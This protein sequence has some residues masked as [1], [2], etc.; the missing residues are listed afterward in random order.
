MTSLSSLL[1]VVHLIG[2]A[3][4]VGCATAKVYLLLK[5]NADEFFVPVFNRV[6]RP[7]TRLI[8][9]GIILLI[10]S[11]IGWLLLGYSFTPLLVV[12]VALVVMILVLGPVID[13]RVEPEFRRLSPAEGE[14]AS[15]EFKAVRRRYLLLEIT[16][17]LLFYAIILLWVLR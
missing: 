10:A 9:T 14:R 17:T 2:L 16:A 7:L 5:C 15:Q 8:V 3:L 11:G 1:S 6:A 13:H 4:G 12:K